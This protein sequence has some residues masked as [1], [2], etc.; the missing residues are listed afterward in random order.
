MKIKPLAKF[1]DK[2]PI[3]KLHSEVEDWKTP[4]YTQGYTKSTQ[5]SG[6]AS[7]FRR[8]S[9]PYMTYRLDNNDQFKTLHEHKHSD[10]NKTRSKSNDA[11]RRKLREIKQNFVNRQKNTMSPTS[12]TQPH[13]KSRFASTQNSNHGMIIRSEFD[14]KDF[15]K[16]LSKDQLFS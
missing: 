16:Q 6:G 4:R 3:I 2:M 11:T 15:L 5:Q 7:D 10:V 1:A 13:P 14:L 12:M 8:M 9:A